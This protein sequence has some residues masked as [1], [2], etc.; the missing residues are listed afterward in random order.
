MLGY[1]P[2]TPDPLRFSLPLG[3][4]HNKRESHNLD[5]ELTHEDQ[6]EIGYKCVA[7]SSERLNGKSLPFAT[8]RPY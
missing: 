2:P 4:I 7:A 1:D 3:F 6:F 8:G 5:S